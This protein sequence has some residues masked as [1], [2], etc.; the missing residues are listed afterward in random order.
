MPFAYAL[1]AIYE[2][3]GDATAP[4]GEGKAGSVHALASAVGDGRVSWQPRQ[5]MVLQRLAVSCPKPHAAAC[6][7]LAVLWFTPVPVAHPHPSLRRAWQHAVTG[8]R[9]EVSPW[10]DAL[11]S[12]GMF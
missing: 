6:L 1:G 10:G 12:G 7:S 5:S 8:P 11:T 9:Q 4:P 3:T 2:G